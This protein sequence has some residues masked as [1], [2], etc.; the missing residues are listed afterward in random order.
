MRHICFSFICL[1][2]RPVTEDWKRYGSGVGE[3]DYRNKLSTSSPGGQN[4]LWHQFKWQTVTNDHN[5]HKSCRPRKWHNTFPISSFRARYMNICVHNCFQDWIIHKNNFQLSTLTARIWVAA[6]TNCDEFRSH[7]QL[8][9]GARFL[10]VVFVPQVA[11]S[12]V[13]NGHAIRTSCC[14]NIKT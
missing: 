6:P 14:G 10:A 4:G 9:A 3:G 12:C 2:V 13:N 5:M 7:D 8:E 11:H 1:L